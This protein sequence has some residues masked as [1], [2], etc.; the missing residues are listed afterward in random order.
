V[1]LDSY[2]KKR[3]FDETPEPAGRSRRTGRKRVFVVQKHAASHLHYDFRLEIGG[4]LVSWAVP[5]GPTLDPSS[6]RFATM[7]EDHPI[8]YV[9]IRRRDGETLLRYKSHFGGRGVG[10]GATG[11]C[12]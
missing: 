9:G 2:R 8:E 11:G 7:T 5:K 10:R 6:K 4:V 1:P 12:R 3:K